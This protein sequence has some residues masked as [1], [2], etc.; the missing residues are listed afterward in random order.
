MYENLLVVW[1]E[2]GKLGTEGNKLQAEADKLWTEVVK[3]W[4]EADKLQ[5]EVVKLGT[6][7]VRSLCGENATIERVDGGNGCLV[8]GIMQFT[9]ETI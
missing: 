4:T 9:N 1:V 2:R 5:A 8:M 6:E 3:L 7:A